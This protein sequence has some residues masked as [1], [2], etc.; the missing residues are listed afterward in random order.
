MDRGGAKVETRGETRIELRHLRY[1]VAVAEELHFGRAAA[2]LNLAQPPLSQQIRQMEELLGFALFVRTSRAVR[3]T[4]AG[5]AYVERAR[6]LLRAASHDI[7]EVRRVAKGEVGSLRIG[8]VGSSMLTALPGALQVYC[9][10][11]P[12]VA[13]ELTEAYS[14]RILEMLEDGSLDVGILRDGDESAAVHAE[15]LL[16]EPYIALAPAR[17]ALARRRRLQVEMLR[18]EPFVFYPKSAGNR[19]WEKPVAFCEAAGFRPR[20]AQVAPHWLTIVSLVGAGIGVSLAPECV[21]RIAPAECA[22]LGLKGVETRSRVE[23][24]WNKAETRPLVELF[25]EVVRRFVGRGGKPGGD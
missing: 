12:E 9:A 4:A 17:H 22:C 5:A 10:E 21:R 3:L 25:A 2:R 8:F 24:A 13:L 16:E 11:Y 7:D 1:F 6:R 18:D 23:I 19:A 14:A 15:L 20:I